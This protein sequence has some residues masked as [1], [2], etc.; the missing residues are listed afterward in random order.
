MHD[1]FGVLDGHHPTGEAMHEYY[2]AY[3]E[4][5]DLL[6]R[7]DFQVEVTEVS[8]LEDGQG[9]RVK[10][11]SNDARSPSSSPSPS[12]STSEV[13]TQKLIIATGVT[14]HP[15]RP[16]LS[17]SSTFAAPIIHSG[18]LGA[19]GASMLLDD[20]SIKTVA[21]LGGGKS[22]Y[23]AVHLAGRAGHQVEWII[24]RSG[25]GPEWVFP[26]H[27]TMGPFSVP[28]EWL[29]TRRIVSFFS[30]C[31]WNDGFA[32]IRR[33]LHGTAL[34]RFVAQ[35]FW[36]RLHAA[37]LADCGMLKDEAT[38]VLE[39]ETRFVV[40]PVLYHSGLSLCIGLFP[41]SVLANR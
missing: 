7:I 12:P 8:R 13:Q 24:R 31:L 18:E 30:P 11:Q 39:P 37:T 16:T 22:A 15:H 9:W 32:G 41:L 6:A 38:K 20:A 21:V 4:R 27:T 14:N 23:D 17:G 34:G 36:A 10:M 25:K 1:G 28:R 3:A 2:E 26:S 5:S 40:L 19:K 33:F 35:K 29:S